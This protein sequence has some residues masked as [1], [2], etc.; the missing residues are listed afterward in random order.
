MFEKN[1]NSEEETLILKN[2]DIMAYQDKAHL[3]Q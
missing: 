3:K 1:G 2:L